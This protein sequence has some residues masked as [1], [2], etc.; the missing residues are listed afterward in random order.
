[1][2]N[3]YKP[4]GVSPLDVI[5]ELQEKDLKYKDVPITY[6]GRLD[7]MAEGVLLLLSGDEVYKK[8]EYMKLDKEYE[9]E[10]LFGFE[11]DTYDILGIAEPLQ[12]TV[13]L[14]DIEKKIVNLTGDISLPLP[15]YSSYKI[16]GKPLFMWAREGKLS[17]IEIP[18]RTTQVH[19]AEVLNSYEIDSE[20]L[21]KKI[22]EKIKK[23]EG[24]FR[25]KEILNKWQEVLREE[26]KYFVIKAKF[27]VSSGT[28]IRSIANHLGGILFSLKRTKVEDFDIKDSQKL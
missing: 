27:K 7:P 9:A 22:E 11:T 18:V 15:P 25:Q 5:R 26:Q 17:D 4:V 13:V 20:E 24:D 2:I 23:T 1:M 14:K 8:E 3:V 6:A 21:F 19:N 12:L 16:E 28:Y 10:I